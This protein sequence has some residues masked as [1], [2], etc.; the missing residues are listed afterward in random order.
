MQVQAEGIVGRQA[1]LGR[2]REALE[3]ARGGRSA[4]VCVLGPPGQGKTALLDRLADEPGGARV[5]RATG[6]EAESEVPF[7]ALDALVRPLLGH[8][9]LVPAAQR[10]ALETALALADHGPV[11]PL[12]IGAGT[13][14]LLAAAAEEGPLLCLVDDVQWLD[15][16]SRR[17]L[18]FAARRLDREPVAVV[19]AARVEDAPPAELRGLD[20]LHLGP[21]DE[22]A[23]AALVQRLGEGRTPEELVRRLVA[24]AGGNPL[25]LHEL[26]ARL[27]PAQLEGREPLVGPPPPDA[28]ARELL[29]ER[30]AALPERARR[31][32]LVAATSEDADL[33]LLGRALQAAGLGLDDLVDA[34]DQG[35]LALRGGRVALRHPLVR[36]VAYHEAPARDRRRAHAAVAS[37][38]ASTDGRRAWHLA[39]ASTGPDEPIAAALEAEAERVRLRAGHR[40]SGRVRVRAAQMTPDPARRVERLMEAAHDFELGGLFAE[41]EEALREARAH[42]DDPLALARIRGVEASLVLRRGRPREAREALVTQARV[43]AEHRPRPA[44]RFFLQAGFASM[45]LIEVEPWLEHSR[46]GLALVPPEDP[47]TRLVGTAQLA[48]ALVAATRLDEAEPLL[49][50]LER[51]L[52]E[53]PEDDPVGGAVEVYAL[54]ARTLIWLERWDLARRILARLERDAR[55]LSAV[56]GLSYVLYVRTL[57]DVHLGRWADAEAALAEQSAL[58]R[59]AGE[60]LFS[61]AA[62]SLHCWLAALRGRG[63]AC[64]GAARETLATATDRSLAVAVAHYGLGLLALGR[65]EVERAVAEFDEVAARAWMPEPGWRVWE[66]DHVEA[67]VRAGERERAEERLR[68]WE[69]DAQRSGRVYA[70]ATAAR[71]RGLLVPDEEVDAAFAR[72]LALHEGLPMPLLRGRALLC[73]GERLRR[74]RRRADARV[75]LR[76]A[77]A[78]FEELGAADWTA[79]A[80]REL[81]AAGGMAPVPARRELEEL[82]PHEIQVARLVADGKTNREVAAALFLAPKTIEHHLSTIF[83]KLDVKR[84]TELARVFAGEPTPVG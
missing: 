22:A 6:V 1:E 31:A 24:A 79:S 76:Q 40:S 64:E 62:G 16:A 77:L 2:L 74:A 68:A 20:A 55:R 70:L 23:C 53:R 84:R 8:L 5:V 82:T 81:R 18:L 43:L 27:T 15:G 72:A 44:A 7:G 28:G 58:A 47:A 60:E 56:A 50:E 59:D 49:A 78:L 33:A 52:L 51:S 17:A 34:E 65:G 19:L 10:R 48:A 57:L 37:A 45:A 42:T 75:P 12:A 26:A 32:L 54:L 35:L 67:L 25:T 29:A 38:L 71:C 80:R 41:A 61:S 36:S 69:A 30:V 3:E 11:D 83:R 73:L 66:P 4:V 46:A 9:D 21:L 13:L 39:A 63:E 14:S